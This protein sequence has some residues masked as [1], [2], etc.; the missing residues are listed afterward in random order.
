MHVENFIAS[1]R[2]KASRLGCRLYAIRG[3]NSIRNPSVLQ[4]SSSRY[5]VGKLSVSE[6]VSVNAHAS[7]IHAMRLLNVKDPDAPGFCRFNIS[8]DQEF[9]DSLTA[10]SMQSTT[11]RRGYPKIEWT[12]LRDRNEAWDL[13]RYNHAMAMLSGVFDSEGDDVLN[14]AGS[15]PKRKSRHFW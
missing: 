1:F 2:T 12:K 11:D 15:S 6:M 14:T 13:F 5:K 3:T 9:F 8:L 10:E 7:K 4:R